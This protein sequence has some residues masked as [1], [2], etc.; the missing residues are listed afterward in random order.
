[1][2]IGE[3]G[4][5]VVDVGAIHESPLQLLHFALWD[6]VMLFSDRYFYSRTINFKIHPLIFPGVLT[7][8]RKKNLQPGDISRVF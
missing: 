5:G 8:N 6:L 3:K 4:A 2:V 1:L 7:E